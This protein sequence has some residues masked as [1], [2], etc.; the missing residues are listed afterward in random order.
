M[1][2]GLYPIRN[3]GVWIDVFPMDGMPGRFRLHY[4][5]MRILNKMRALSV[6]RILPKVPVWAFPVVYLAWKMTQLIGFQYFI[7]QMERLACKYDYESSDYVSCAVEPDSVKC[8]YEKDIFA[9]SVSLSFE[10][11]SFEVPVLYKKYLE[12]TYGDYMQLPPIE[13]RLGHSFEAQWK[14]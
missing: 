10:N 13:K 8:V 14:P 9:S 11:E 5:K 6:H 3:M 2:K 12:Y 4:M 1:E 7:N